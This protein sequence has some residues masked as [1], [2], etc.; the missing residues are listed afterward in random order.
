MAL[1]EYDSELDID[2]MFATTHKEIWQR[3]G[4][5]GT[6]PDQRLT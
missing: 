5:C 6:F 1:T 3:L 4:E 2:P